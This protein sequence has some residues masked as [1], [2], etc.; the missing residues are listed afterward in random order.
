MVRINKV[1]TKS[2][3]RGKTQLIGGEKVAK[4]N[5]RIECYGT[6][7][8]LN[9]TLG[10]FGSAL[11]G[12]AAQDRLAP[13]LLRIQNE[14]FNVGTQLATPDEERRKKL[15]D[16]TAVHIETLESEIDELNEELPDLQSF[17]LPGGSQASSSAH[18]AR[19]VCRR[20]ERLVV[21]L[22]SSE[23]VDTRHLIYL[24]RLSDSLFVF[25][26]YCMVADKREELLWQPEEV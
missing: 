4:N 1:Y 23:T 6:I 22:A 10:M 24:N 3:D 14:L 17:V 2:G 18:L 12:S 15:P 25:G 13:K 19:C 5:A 26:R 7:D 20:A 16:I 21:A 8:E 9:A 11:E